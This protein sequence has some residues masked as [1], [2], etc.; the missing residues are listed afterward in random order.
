M[1]L[2]DP[3]ELHLRAAC[4]YVEAGMFDE[5]QAE[6]EKIDPC[7]QLLPELLAARF[8]L[9]RAL[10]KWDVMASVARK[11]TEWNPEE[12]RNFVHWAYATG[13]VKSIHAAH[14]ILTRAAALHP[15][16]AAI[17]FNLSCYEAQIGRPDRAKVHLKRADE[18]N[19][20]F[21]L[22]ALGNPDLES[23]WLSQST[24]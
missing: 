21:G 3:H 5:A 10:E 2:N 24:E 12:P 18:V 1:P 11:L 17:Q 6:L 23:L 22:M 16:D 4:A 9:Y 13:R 14:A 19:P 8:P 20:N 15:A 7:S